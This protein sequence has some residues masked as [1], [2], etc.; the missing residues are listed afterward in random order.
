MDYQAREAEQQAE[1][2]GAVFVDA[3]LTPFFQCACG[4]MLDFCPEASL[5]IQ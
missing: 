5:T 2:L 4:Q 1:E 3:R